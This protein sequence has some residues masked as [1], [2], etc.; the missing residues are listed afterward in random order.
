MSSIATQRLMAERKA[1][2]KDRPFGFTAGPTKEVA[3]ETTTTTTSG[4][5]KGGN[6]CFAG[7]PEEMV[8]LDGNYTATFLKEKL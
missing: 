7:T 5:D 4:G 6:V 2:R 1:W 8:K 3:S